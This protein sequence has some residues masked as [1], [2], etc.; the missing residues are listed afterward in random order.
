MNTLNT[1]AMQNL[2]FCIL[3]FLVI[4][5]SVFSL[6][7]AA[8]RHQNKH[9]TLEVVSIYFCIFLLASCE[10]LLITLNLIF[11]SY[12]INSLLDLYTISSYGLSIMIFSFIFSIT[13]KTKQHLKFSLL[14]LMFL[15]FCQY[16][17]YFIID[18]NFNGM[19]SA[20][21]GTPLYYIL[22][23]IFICLSLFVIS[24]LIV[25]S[26]NT[27]TKLKKRSQFYLILWAFGPYLAVTSLSIIL[28]QLN[29][30]FTTMHIVLLSLVPQ[31][32]IMPFITANKVLNVSSGFTP[33]LKETIKHLDN[34]TLR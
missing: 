8:L 24:W 7:F 5:S 26:K 34:F 28:M 11:P 27:K 20:R 29:P 33:V 25:T 2:S 19:F 4:I 12:K 22:E 31:I 15:I 13:V 6:A 16:K 3:P 21:I 10:F 23:V 14:F 1:L 32:L 18:Y 17:G 30:T 9:F